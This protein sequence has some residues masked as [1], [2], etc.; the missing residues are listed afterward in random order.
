MPQSH[1][2]LAF[3]SVHPSVHPEFIALFPHILSLCQGWKSKG[4]YSITSHWHC[5]QVEAHE[6]IFF[7]V[8]EHSLLL[9]RCLISVFSQDSI[10]HYDH[11]LSLMWAQSTRSTYGGALIDWIA[12]CNANRIPEDDRL[13][14]SHELLSMFIASKISHDG[15]SHAGNIMS[16]LR[17]WHIVQGFNWSFGED[18]LVLG[19]KHTIS[20]NAPPSTTR[21]LRPPVLIAHLEALRLNLDLISN[22]FDISVYMVAC[23]AFWGVSRLGELVISSS[24]DREPEKRVH[25][26]CAFSWDYL[27]DTTTLSGAHWHIPWT[28]TTQFCGATM[29][30][31]DLADMADCSPVKALK[32]HLS[33]SSTLPMSA[34]LFTY[35]NSLS[36]VSWSPMTKSLFLTHCRSIWKDAGLGECGGHSF[37]IGG[38][39]ELLM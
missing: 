29:V 23:C 20:S 10:S 8:S 35:S 25:R 30:L 6:Q 2:T 34:N 37:R 12:W 14:I 4:N 11:G 1:P 26:E 7:W 5:P 31:T 16:G 33:C 39:T 28:K 32:H 13:P 38:T 27:P 3:K 15:A 22:P 9:C 19:L 18:P 21:P 17:A 36:S 24:S